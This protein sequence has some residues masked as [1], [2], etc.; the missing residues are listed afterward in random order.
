[1]IRRLL[2]VRP[3]LVGSLSNCSMSDPAILLGLT[4]EGRHV[5]SSTQPFATVPMQHGRSKRTKGR[6]AQVQLPLKNEQIRAKQLRVV[7]PEGGETQILS[8]QE[9]REEATRVGLDLVLASPQAEPPV[10]RIV[11]WEKMIYSMRQK[12]KAQER[13]ARESKKLASPKEIRIGCHIASHDL[14]V[15]MAS[16]RKILQEHHQV[17]KISVVFR[18]GREIEPAKQVLDSILD[19]LGDIGKV[20]DPKHL[21]KPQMNR[22]AVQLEPLHVPSPSS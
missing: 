8:L 21:Q 2:A 15:K 7:F 11:S 6:D 14:E 20:K 12:Q 18:G 19:S 1:M 17:L 10:A 9:A 3:S 5:Y 13:A 16:A 4:S 22:W